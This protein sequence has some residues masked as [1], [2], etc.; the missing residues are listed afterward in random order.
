MSSAEFNFFPFPFSLKV[1]SE[2]YLNGLK[3]SSKVAMIVEVLYTRWHEAAIYGF[4]TDIYDA[5][6]F[7]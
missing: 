2:S 3:E 7:F 1:H 5:C 4:A 6:F